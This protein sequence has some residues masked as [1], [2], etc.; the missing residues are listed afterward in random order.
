MRSKGGSTYRLENPRVI[1]GAVK[2]GKNRVLRTLKLPP[3][4][5]FIET[6]LA[7]KWRRSP[8]V[9]YR[10]RDDLFWTGL[11]KI[12][13]DQAVELPA[14]QQ[15]HDAKTLACADGTVYVV[16]PVA[17]KPERLWVASG[18]IGRKFQVRGLLPE[19]IKG[20]RR[21]GLAASPNQVVY[22]IS[23]V[24][25]G[26]TSQFVFWNLSGDFPP[27]PILTPWLVKSLR[28]PPEVLFTDARTALVA[29]SDSGRIHVETFGPIP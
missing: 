28:H 25:N 26:K 18:K 10:D 17:V 20:T 29:W 4:Y 7:G 13:T 6:S 16:V 23:L 8:R 19:G 24:P 9:L 3:K 15:Y 14:G 12:E 2:K 5:D 1:Y 21:F 11:R 27:D 22:L